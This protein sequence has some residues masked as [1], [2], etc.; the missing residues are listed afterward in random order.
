[1]NFINHKWLAAACIAAG[2]LI[3]SGAYAQWYGGIGAGQATVKIP[4]V[5]TATLTG[6][7]TE[8]KGTSYKLYGGYQF[9]TNWGAELGYN[10]LGKKFSANFTASGVGGSAPIN[11][12]N[13]YFAGTGTLPLGGGFSLLAKFGVVRNSMTGGGSGCSGTACVL[14]GED[15]NRIQPLMGAGA[16]LAL[17]KTF[18]LR[19]EYEDYGKVSSDNVWGTGASGAIKASSWYLSLKSG[20]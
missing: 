12:H 6:S 15:K 20:F 2:T 11:V 10:N 4:D 14:V 18:A 13:A 19:L 16:E 9:T 17:G 8:T 1:M 3:S 5:R 7:G